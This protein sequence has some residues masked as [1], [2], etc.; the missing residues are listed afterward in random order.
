M[1]KQNTIQTLDLDKRDDCL[2][3][4]NFLK[5]QGCKFTDPLI[6]VVI[7]IKLGAAVKGLVNTNELLN[8]VIEEMIAEK[9]KSKIIRL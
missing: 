3:I 1:N 6:S 5:A 7:P 2:T 8:K 9:K 4:Y